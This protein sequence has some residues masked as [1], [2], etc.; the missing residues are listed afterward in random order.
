MP[1]PGSFLSRS[2]QGR[3]SQVQATI[4]LL[5]LRTFGMYRDSSLEGYVYNG[6]KLPSMFKGPGCVLR[7]RLASRINRA[8]A[9]N[10]IP[11][12]TEDRN[13]Y[14]CAVSQIRKGEDIVINYGM[15]ACSLGDNN[16]SIGIS[17]SIAGAW[18]VGQKA[19]IAPV[20]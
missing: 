10:S 18:L 12:F 4:Q 8:C 15:K 19:S 3:S 11:R 9:L 1:I 6:F 7:S 17:G 5:H 16:G 13:I 2:F 14:V 20:P